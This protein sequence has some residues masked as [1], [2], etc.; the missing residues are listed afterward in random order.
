MPHT[1]EDGNYRATGVADLR[2]HLRQQ[3]ADAHLALRDLQWGSR[4][5]LEALH[6]PLHPEAAQFE[7]SVSLKIYLGS[8][9]VTEFRKLREAAEA[10]R[11]QGQVTWLCLPSGD[12][13]AA[14]VPADDARRIV[15]EAALND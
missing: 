11:V 6:R 9:T 10:A 13:I 8:I 14:I 12:P 2:A 4:I 1:H 7:P 15:T 3:H 5:R